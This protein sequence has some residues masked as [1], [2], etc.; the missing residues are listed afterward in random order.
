MSDLEI[1]AA[2]PSAG[3]TPEGEVEAAT[4]PAVKK[5][6]LRAFV[7]GIKPVTRHVRLYGNGGARVDLDVIDRQIDEAKARRQQ[8]QANRL[9]KE[10]VQVV[11]ALNS[12]HVI[13]LTVVGWTETRA[14][15]FA[16][17]LTA[18]GVTSV[19]ERNL[20]Q[21]AAQII[22]IDG[23]SLAD[24]GITVEDVYQMLADL[25]EIPGMSSQISRLVRIVA[26]TNADPAVVSVPL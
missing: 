4:A 26:E 12:Q 3:N 7:A 25:Y 15:Q 2:E 21:A 16:K 6:D 14:D 8:A 20:R 13:D 22:E 9:Q 17:D 24:G 10:R 19:L 23:V 18:G 11:Q 1:S 5:L